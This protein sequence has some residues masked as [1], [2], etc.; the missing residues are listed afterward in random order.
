MNL[1]SKLVFSVEIQHFEATK[2]TL[3]ERSSFSMWHAL[4]N[5]V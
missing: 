2:P 4:P 1:D 3:E 5:Y